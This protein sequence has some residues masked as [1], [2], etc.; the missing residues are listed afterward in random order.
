MSTPP[1]IVGAV[2]AHTRPA[3]EYGQDPNQPSRGIVGDA[4]ARLHGF[5]VPVVAGGDTDV[6]RQFQGTVDYSLQHFVGAANPASTT[7]VSRD[8]GNATLS[9]A[10]VAGPEL[11]PARRMLADRLRRRV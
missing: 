2:N 1:P 6:S 3:V 11:D 10:I 4:L 8:G 9:D 5:F 7:V